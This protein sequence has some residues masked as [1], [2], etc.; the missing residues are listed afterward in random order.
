MIN[1]KN[2]PH[3]LF[4]PE[5]A[6]KVAKELND[7][8]D[9]FYEAVHAPLGKGMSYIAIYENRSKVNFVGLWK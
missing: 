1:L 6:E 3:K 5:D 8:D 2:D 7:S 9:W 4:S